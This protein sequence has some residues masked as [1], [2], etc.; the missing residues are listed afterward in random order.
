LADDFA[1]LS[2][3]ERNGQQNYKTGKHKSLGVLV[4]RK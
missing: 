4:Q 2:R 1:L 3:G